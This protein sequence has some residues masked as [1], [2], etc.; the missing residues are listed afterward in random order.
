M[1]GADAARDGESVKVSCVGF[2]GLSVEFR[3]VNFEQLGGGGGG[4][5]GRSFL[6]SPLDLNTRTL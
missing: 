1:P 6:A 2:G 3:G 5:R 4:V